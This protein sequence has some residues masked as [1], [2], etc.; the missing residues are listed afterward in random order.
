MTSIHPTYKDEYVFLNLEQQEQY[1][2]PKSWSEE[3]VCL[4]RLAASVVS[5][6]ATAG[7]GADA[8]IKQARRSGDDDRGGRR[9]G[10]PVPGNWQ[11]SS[12]SRHRL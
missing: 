12:G 10:L 1:N 11:A 5:A 7:R 3:E 8:V 4:R 2:A 9:T 6:T